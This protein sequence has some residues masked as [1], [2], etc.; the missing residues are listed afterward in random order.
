MSTEP[1]TVSAAR[2]VP[3]SPERVY[4]LVADIENHWHFSDRYLRLEGIDDGRRGGRIVIAG[5]LGLRRT[6]RTT[7]TTE[8]APHAFGGVAAVGSRTRAVAHWRIEP[9]E[10]GA[11]VVLESTVSSLGAFDRLLLTLGGRWWLRRGFARVLARLADHLDVAQALWAA[12]AR[13]CA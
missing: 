3:H 4:A 7:V 5:P 1:V 13:G 2:V 11:R 6:A 9:A 8:H 10:R 12:P